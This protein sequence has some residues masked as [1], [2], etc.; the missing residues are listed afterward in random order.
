MAAIPG[1]DARWVKVR[2]RL[3]VPRP[4]PSPSSQNRLCPPPPGP[5]LPP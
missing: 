3:L 2:S 5:T 4:D 1:R